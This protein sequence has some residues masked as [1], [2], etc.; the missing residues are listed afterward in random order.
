MLGA[1][2]GTVMS[3]CATP[4]LAAALALAGSGSAFGASMWWGAAL[5][6]AYG[7]GHS[8]LLLVAG[9]IPGAATTL[10]R[11]AAWAQGWLPGRRSFAV[12]L[13]AAGL[14]WVAQGLEIVA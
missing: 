11:R 5:L 1:L 6:L 3:P 10:M 14:W 8:A 13:A 12:L 7:I 2:I 4:A 9:A